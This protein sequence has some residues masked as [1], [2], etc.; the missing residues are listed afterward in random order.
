M[1]VAIA[2]AHGKIGLLLGSLLAERGETVIG[3]I[4]NPAQEDDLHAAGV[5]PVLCDLEGDDDVAAAIRGADAV[6]F[7]A[8][9]GAG[10][11]GER[12]WTLDYGGAVK[13]IAA[14]KAEGAR[15]YLLVSSIGAGHPPAEGGG[16][17]GE[18]LRAK[19]KADRE[20]E[21]SGL[22]YTI[23]RPASLTDDHGTGMITVGQDLDG[24]EIPRADVAATI[25]VAL[26]TPATIGKTFE[27]AKGDTLIAQALEELE[28]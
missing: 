12:K 19:A 16:V 6:V 8:G 7:A 25:A 13:L 3:L 22:D 5:E 27:E 23:I 28:G 24:G 26:V 18:Y 10:S 21:A 20:L 14:A 2:G 9:A 15:R 17:F 4:R 11:G 1:E